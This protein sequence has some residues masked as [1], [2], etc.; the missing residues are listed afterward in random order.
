M[1][2][3]LRRL[4]LTAMMLSAS[5]NYLTVASAQSFIG[6][7]TDD[8]YAVP[9]HT[10]SG[11]SEAV[12][13]VGD[14]DNEG[15]LT[16]DAMVGNAM[17]GNLMSG[18]MVGDL[19]VQQV[20]GTKYIGDDVSPATAI[21]SP[22]DLATYQNGHALPIESSYGK[23]GDSSFPLS[24]GY[25][26]DGP[27]GTSCNSVPAGRG[28]FRNAVCDDGNDIWMK[29]EL[30]LWFP[31]AR[32]T[33]PLGVAAVDP[34]DLFADAPGATVFNDPFGNGLTPGFRG[35]VGRYFAD[36]LFGLGGRVWVLG[37]DSE[38]FQ[39]TSPGNTPFFGV[40]FFQL[41]PGSPLGVGEDTVIVTGGGA[42]G[43]VVARSALSVVAAELYGRALVGEG[44]NHR[45]EMIGG[46]SHFNITDEFDLR[47]VQQTIALD[48]IFNDAF[49]TRNE[50]HGG[51]I[52][53]ELSLRRGRWTASSLTKVHLG[54]MAQRVSATG[55]SVTQIPGVP[56]TVTQDVNEGLFARGDALETRSQNLFT[57]APEMNLKVGYQF[58]DHVNFH[59]GYSFIYWSN[60]AL[61]GE[62]MDRNLFV[63]ST[64]LGATG[65]GRYN[66]I[67]SDG[68]W[69]Q[70]IDL[71]MTLEF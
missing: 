71:G 50:F 31:Q 22:S 26:S 10:V 14:F 3:E 49:R 36:G 29:A 24:S 35:D 27:C 55:N 17:A 38:T 46:Y 33:P 62:Q 28:S 70:G 41:D 4:T 12:P 34:V 66:P 45:F 69:V 16:G 43:S 25:A 18:N 57:F 2:N 20:S 51:Q 67:R 42:Q 58:R 56:P 54:T 52:G 60:V 19:G 21:T 11:E 32:N 40:P 39:Y 15:P 64:N 1:K 23:V 30:L 6:D 37:D 8:Y 65:P 59:V 53:N 68:F 61:A 7:A 5:A 48:T 13:S 47:V 9:A 63:D 44:K